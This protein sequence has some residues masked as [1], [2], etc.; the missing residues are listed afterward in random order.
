MSDAWF[1]ARFALTPDGWLEHAVIHVAD[2]RIVR[3]EQNDGSVLPRRYDCN[4]LV[5]GCVNVHSH[6]FQV[7]LRGRT[8]RF[9]GPDD[10]FWS[11]RESM[12]RTAGEMRPD[13]L[14]RIAERLYTEMR[15]SG[16]TTVCEFHYVHGAHVGAD[17]PL[18][19]ARAI[20]AAARSAGIRL[21][22]LPVLYRYSGFGSRAP[23]PEQRPFILDTTT[24]LELFD[25][26][27]DGYGTVGYAPHSLR[28]VSE[29]DIRTLLAHRAAS[30]PNAPV[31]IHVAEQMREVNEC[32]IALGMRPVQFLLDRFK[33]DVHWC[34]IH[35]THM[36]DG[37]RRRLASCGA[38]VGLCP[39]TEADL[40]DGRFQLRPFL[41]SKGSIAIGSDSNVCTDAAEE[42]RFLDY[43]NRLETRRR[44]AFQVPAGTASGTWLYQQMLRG[45]RS[46]AGTDTGRLVPGDWADFLDLSGNGDPDDVLGAWIY[47]DR[48]RI[49]ATYVGGC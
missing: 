14:F 35:A 5:P 2:G 45:G 34:M 27:S 17:L 16:Y 3:I 49:R 26:V 46:A 43:Q 40:G 38:T 41:A 11:W 44:N 47:G 39:T 19:M 22:L 1:Q 48:S 15:G 9:Q 30:H 37:E 36:D 4:V 13:A 10:D 42:I 24:Y 29:D 20:Q 21:V 28:A 6:A 12:Y 31:H 32:V 7:L 18:L 25:A 33:P 23:R 8:S